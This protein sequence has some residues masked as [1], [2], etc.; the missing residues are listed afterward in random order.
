MAKHRKVR[1]RAAIAVESRHCRGRRARGGFLVS[2][3]EA[4]TAA[5]TP[6]GRGATCVPSDTT[7]CASSDSTG[8]LG[9]ASLAAATEPFNIFWGNGNADHPDAG[10]FMA[11][12]S[13][14]TPAPARHL[15]RR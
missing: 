4:G 7:S 15:Q 12:A 1:S 9:A 14:M 8:K 10:L 3:A 13:A 6:P 5:A 2:L 11:T